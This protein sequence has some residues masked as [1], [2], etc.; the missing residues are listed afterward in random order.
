MKKI[1]F[2]SVN[3]NEL[4]SIKGGGNKKVLN[5]SCFINCRGSGYCMEGVCYCEHTTGVCIFL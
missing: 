1:S 4:R 5:A 2:E 3:R